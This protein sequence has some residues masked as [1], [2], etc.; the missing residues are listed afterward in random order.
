MWIL[1]NHTN[2]YE[3][4]CHKSYEENKGLAIRAYNRGGN[5]VWESGKAFLRR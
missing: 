4:N 3:I 5:S 1:N 2:E